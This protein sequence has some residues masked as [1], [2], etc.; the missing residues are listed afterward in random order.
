[1]ANPKPYKGAG[2]PVPVM[3]WYKVTQVPPRVD[4]G[5]VLDYMDSFSEWVRPGAEPKV[6]FEVRW[7]NT[8]GD[9]EVIPSKPNGFSHYH[10][11]QVWNQ[12][13]WRNWPRMPDAR[14]YHSWT[15]D[16]MRYNV[17]T[18]PRMLDRSF[19]YGPEKRLKR[20]QRHAEV[21]GRVLCADPESGKVEPGGKW[22]GI[23]EMFI[24]GYLT[25]AVFKRYPPHIRPK[26]KQEIY[27]RVQSE[28]SDWL[29]GFRL[30]VLPTTYGK[31]RE[32]AIE[33]RKEARS[34]VNDCIDD[35]FR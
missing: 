31:L 34:I 2:K 1:M 4:P 30:G 3:R 14:G 8:D 35:W 6:P 17:S 13:R 23:V 27:S 12:G 5:E 22:D 10:D 15:H 19:L 21:Y 25:M 33:G 11:F 29:G 9:L 26:T 18:S 24:C 7:W 20:I 32:K 16:L 28:I